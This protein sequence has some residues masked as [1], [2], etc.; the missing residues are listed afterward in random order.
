MITV[1]KGERGSLEKINQ[2]TP[3]IWVNLVKPNS[4]EIARLQHELEIPHEFL[5]S[6][7]DTDERSRTD[8]DGNT[9]L[10]L[11]RIPRSLGASSDIPFITIPLAIIFSDNFIVTVCEEENDIIQEF[12]TGQVAGMSTAKRNQFLLSILLRAAKNYLTYLRQI[13]REVDILEDELQLSMKNQELIELL[14][15]Q[16]SLVYFTT[17]LKSNELMMERL[18]RSGIFS[19]FPDDQELLEDVLT[20]NQQ[21]IEMV[22]ISNNILSQMMDAFASIISNNLNVV[23]KFLTSATIVLMFP[24]LVASFYGM[25]VELPLQNSPFAFL[26]TLIISFGLSLI[27]VIV[28]QKKNWF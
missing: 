6:A 11:L 9:H 26:F 22:G 23:M 20:E 2:L 5:I 15:Y 14:K 13:D 24:T 25:N 1:L 10:V 12:L 27:V 8:K 19:K 18:Q 17:A 21:A 4:D 3:D 7:Q 28:F 16:K